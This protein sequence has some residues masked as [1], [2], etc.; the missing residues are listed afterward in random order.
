[1]LPRRVRD[2]F[3]KAKAVLQLRLARGVRLNRSFYTY[4]GSKRLN[5]GNVRPLQNGVMI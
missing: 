1:M 2:G 5:K 4:N 3:R